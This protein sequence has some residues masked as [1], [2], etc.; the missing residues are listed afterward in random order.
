MSVPHALPAP[1]PEPAAEQADW[2]Q[3]PNPRWRSRDRAESAAC[4]RGG[5]PRLTVV[6]APTGYGKTTAIARWLHEHPGESG[7]A[8]W[9]H[10]S[11]QSAVALWRRMARMLAPHAAPLERTRADP[12]GDTMHLGRTLSE[13]V[14]LVLDD[15]HRVTARDTDIAL[16]DLALASPRLT[17]VIAG[18]R[19]TL[20]D[21]PF[22]AARNQITTIGRHELRLSG[23]EAE[24]IAVA[25]G[26]AITPRLRV[27]LE[28]ADGW[29]LAIQAVL[30]RRDAPPTP[31]QTQ[32]SHPAEAG[33][34]DPVANLTSFALDALRVAGK[35]GSEV[36]LAA[37]LVSAL[38]GEQL[39]EVCHGDPAAARETAE[40]LEELGLLV[41][42]HR[43]CG[44]EYRCHRSVA[45]S[46]ARHAAVTLSASQRGSLH[47]SRARAL[48]A[49]TPA[50]AFAHYCEAGA[51][52]SAETLLAANFSRITLDPAASA[53][54]LRAIPELEL[55]NH[56]T[57]AAA[58]LLAEQS[59]AA[60][61]PSRLQFLFRLWQQALE[62]TGAGTRCA[63]ESS[64]Y[65]PYLCQS[66]VAHRLRGDLAKARR[67]LRR[68]EDR[69]SPSSDPPAPQP[70]GLSE[71]SDAQERGQPSVPPA[72]SL[73]NYYRE[74]AAT[75]LALGQLGKARNTLEQLQQY[76]LQ[77][78][79]AIPHTEPKRVNPMPSQRG[80]LVWRIAALSDLALTDMVDGHVRRAQQHLAEFDALAASAKS[81][82]GKAPWPGAEI[83]RALLSQ[84]LHDDALL[85]LAS[86]RLTPLGDTYELW[87][88]ELIAE[89]FIIRRS[90]G[91]PHALPYLI[92]GIAARGRVRPVPQPWRTILMML[93]AMLN[94]SLGNLTRA[95][96][97]L[98]ED[99]RDIAPVQLEH[100]RLELF[101]NND[102]D[103]L[104]RAQSVGARRATKRQR[105]DASLIIATAAYSCGRTAEA[106][107][108][109]D[110]AA[111][112]ITKYGLN[113]A[114]M[115][116]PFEPLLALTQ[117]ATSEGATDL[118]HHLQ[119]IPELA[120]AQRY[121]RLTE[122]ELRTL[123]A[124]SEHRT[125]NLAAASLFVTPATVKK[126]LVAV[127]RKLRVGDRDAAILRARRTGIL[128]QARAEDP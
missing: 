12:L 34:I 70:P 52:D 77:Q 120:R 33:P 107:A 89:V 78:P 57:L 65:L 85:S 1:R 117:A 30:R 96:E 115:G 90:R 106:F 81:T 112:L 58:L 53:G 36:L 21:G 59:L 47:R 67:L 95:R 116:V 55:S 109:L 127:Y 38:D 11:R 124:V 93:E 104:V 2:Q 72:G 39:L 18:R 71:P 60:V 80:E 16:A 10:C 20:L 8:L 125:A 42:E 100:A 82:A 22:V 35:Q 73:P 103:A 64:M 105:A 63:P 102:I 31:V 74:I 3:P 17:L 113:S 99:T 86:Q 46:L 13:R 118:T 69:L 61:A 54:I 49:S 114:V 25:S 76:L 84:E 92:S 41:A 68:L 91:L 43:S 88:L 111:Q 98:A 62:D 40:A 56:P 128:G 24:E 51:Y 75:A 101:S 29:P 14:L 48:E 7:H 83:A 26:V 5:L 19:V 123:L 37:A 9:L 6:C 79:A 119:S 108:A 97:I 28:Q 45:S 126:H 23:G 110:D 87:P 122:M 27:A 32:A 44:L 66:M 121:E 50:A 94:S 15:Y 4:Q